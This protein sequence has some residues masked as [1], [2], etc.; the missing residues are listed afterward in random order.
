MPRRII[1]QPPRQRRNARRLEQR[2]DRHLNPKRRTQPPD[3]PDRQ[4]RVTAQR[5]E[6]VID[7]HRTHPQ[8]LG[9]QAAQQLLLRGARQ[10]P[11][12]RNK[13]RHRQRAPVELAVRR[14]RKTLQHNDRRRHHVVRQLPPERHPQ[15]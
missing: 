10:T 2:A 6:V 11:R 1:R 12:G 3:Q 4:Q 14:Q 9:K 7:P 8:H 15:R 13:P 5:K